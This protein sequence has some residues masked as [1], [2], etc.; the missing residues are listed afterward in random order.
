MIGLLAARVVVLIVLCLNSLMRRHAEQL[1]VAEWPERLAIVKGWLLR[2]ELI[3]L[4]TIP[5][6]L[7]LILRGATVDRYL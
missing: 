1:L 6:V 7:V 5:P 4:I 2:S 3:Q